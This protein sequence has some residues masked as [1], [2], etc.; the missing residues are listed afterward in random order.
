MRFHS[1]SVC[2]NYECHLKPLLCNII[3]NKQ[4]H[5]DPMLSNHWCEESCHLKITLRG[6][7]NRPMSYRYFW[8]LDSKNQMQG[9]SNYI[10]CK[11]DSQIRMFRS[12]K[13]FQNFK[14]VINKSDKC[15]GT[16]CDQFIILAMQLKFGF[17][18][19]QR[20]MM[21]YAEFWILFVIFLRVD[22]G[23]F[24]YFA[25]FTSCLGTQ[26]YPG[27]YGNTGFVRRNS[28]CAHNLWWLGR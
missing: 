4:S 6:T 27:H 23:V 3:L 15:V 20:N 14:I 1:S 26:C 13:H 8:I 12:Y 21:L 28:A 2:T 9:G 17:T 10:W 18:G 19:Y 16:G 25:G 5:S 11:I 22:I 7:W 24:F